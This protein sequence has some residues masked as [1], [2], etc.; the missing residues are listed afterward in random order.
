MM[1]SV[2]I[3]F[4]LALLG[5][6]T[7]LVVPPEASNQ[8]SEPKS[9]GFG[10][11]RHARFYYNPVM[12]ACDCFVYG[13][14]LGNDN[15]FVRLEDCMRTCR[16]NEKLQTISS[17]CIDNFGAD[18]INFASFSTGAVTSQ[19]VP[20]EASNQCSEPKSAGMGYARHARFYYNP[21]TRACDCFIY[22]G[23]LGNDNNFL[24][25]DDCMRTCRV[26]EKL[27]TI[28]SDCI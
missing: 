14:F 17:D 11:A 5:A 23:F 1:S 22:G 2:S 9:V 4:S 16:V 8:C 6:V 21:D 10:Y 20:P 7:S 25:L 24:H 28:S 27:Q 13:G 26:N 15:N 3:L 18:D 12:G 19:V